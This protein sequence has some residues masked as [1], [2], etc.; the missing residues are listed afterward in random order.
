[1][2]Y[3]TILSF[4]IREKGQKFAKIQKKRKKVKKALD[5]R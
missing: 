2:E 3:S 5:K 1:M 4:E